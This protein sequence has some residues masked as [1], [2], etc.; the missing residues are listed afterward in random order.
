MSVKGRP[1]EFD[2]YETLNTV[3]EL[4]WQKGYKATSFADIT[5]ATGVSKQSLYNVYGDKKKIFTRAL[6][7]YNTQKLDEAK[8]FLMDE[9]H[10][11]L[12]NL[13]QFLI[14]MTKSCKGDRGCL[15]A[16]SLAE[17]GQE[18]SDL[19]DI[20]KKNMKAIKSILFDAIERAKNAQE[21]SN[22]F[23]SDAIASVLFT[24]TCGTSVLKRAGVSPQIMKDT[25]EIAISLLK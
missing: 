12:E 10:S 19:Y 4:F 20:F 22:D 3:I 9:A 21:L 2:T 24:L 6:L 15:F 13:K 18:D 1:Q 11:P 23:D 16:N 14:L 8:V 25:A 5:E 7:N 17:F